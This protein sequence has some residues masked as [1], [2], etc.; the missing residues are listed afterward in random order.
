MLRLA[1]DEN[2]NH[3][4]IRGLLRRQPDIDLISIQAAGLSG[5]TDPT[6]LAWAAA[7][8]RLLLTHD[9]TTLTRYAYDRVK[10]G[11]RL[12]G[13]V[14][15]SRSVPLSQAIDDLLLLT[16]LSRDDEWEGR[17]LYLPLR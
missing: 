7:E 5:A 10:A 15:V 8:G 1:A 17:I 11:Q 16:E 12:P 9:V 14:A 3:D 6:V 2:F 13:V 4:I